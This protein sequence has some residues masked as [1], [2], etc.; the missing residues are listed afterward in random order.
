MAFF[1]NSSGTHMALSI[2]VGFI[3]RTHNGDTLTAP[4]FPARLTS[5]LASGCLSAR[6]CRLT[7]FISYRGAGITA[8]SPL[9]HSHNSPSAAVALAQADG[10][11]YYS[12][13]TPIFALKQRERLTTCSNRSRLAL[14]ARSHFAVDV[15][16]P[17]AVDLVA[18]CSL[19]RKKVNLPD[20][21]YLY[22]EN[23]SLRK[24]ATH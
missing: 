2:V 11:N 1:I 20:H 16:Y 4:G 18:S 6:Q 12:R 8:E 9:F 23:M 19:L 14:T 5:G 21:V 15:S 3:R 17:L 7:Q 10:D 24:E 13:S 22:S